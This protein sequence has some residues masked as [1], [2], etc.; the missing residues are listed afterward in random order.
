MATKSNEWKHDA[1]LEEAL[2][3]YINQNLK[4]AEMLDFVKERFPNYL[5]SL[6]TLDRRLRHFGLYYNDRNVTANEVQKI[7]HEEM[8]G[9]GRLLGYRAMHQKVRQVHE[10]RAPRKA[11]HAAMYLEDSE[12]LEERRPCMKKKKIKGNFVSEGPNWVHSLDGHDKMMGYQNSTFPI[13][14]YRY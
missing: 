1:L 13:D 11:I 6:P 2:N 9:P 8:M 14:I 10:L 4:R 5:W 12:L 7:V 3:T